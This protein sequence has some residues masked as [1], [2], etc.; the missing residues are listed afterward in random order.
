VSYGA[1]HFVGCLKFS[2][3][4]KKPAASLLGI[5][6]GS[7]NFFSNFDS[8]LFSQDYKVSSWLASSAE[9]TLASRK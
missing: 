7:S 8:C 6:G 1:G 2:D 5:E 3:F 9:Q 4:W